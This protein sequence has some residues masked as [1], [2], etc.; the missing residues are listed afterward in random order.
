[1]YTFIEVRILLGERLQ[2]IRKDHGDTQQVLADKLH[3]SLYSIRCWEQGKSDPSHD[4][5]VAIC[6]LYGISADYLLGLTDEDP[7]FLQHKRKKLTPE[8]RTLL[9]R[10]EAFL[11]LEQTTNPSKDDDHSVK[12]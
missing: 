2:D 4:L 6:R 11:L 12:L 3:V 5:L 10:F 8:N 9:R 1:M 7:A